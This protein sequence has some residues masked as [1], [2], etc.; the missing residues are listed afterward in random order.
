[1]NHPES[2][3][4]ESM[5]DQQPI[6][7]DRTAIRR[8]DFSLPIK[9]LLRDGLVD[10]TT[11]VFDYGCGHGEDIRFLAERGIP[12]SG[13]DPAFRPGAPQNAADVVNIGY[14]IN[15]I[16][17]SDER[18][19]TLRRAWGLC[20][21]ILAVSAQIEVQGRGSKAVP[22]ADGV[23]T[24][25]GTFQKYFTQD[26]LRLYIETQL[27]TEPVAAAPG[28]FLVFR[29]SVLRESWLA[30]RYRRRSAAPPKRISEQRFEEHRAILEPLMNA[31]AMLGRLPEADEWIGEEPVISIFGS[32]KRAFALI[33][34]VT[35]DEAW[36]LIRARKSEDFLVYLALAK[37]R[38]RPPISKL[39]I[40]LQ[41]DIR[42]FFGTYT[43]AC[44][45]ADELLF[46]A[47][48]TDAIDAACRESAIGKL[49]PNALYVHRSALDYLAPLL[50]V[51]EGC[52][53][54][55]IGEVADANLVKLHRVSGKVSYLAYP[56]FE[57]DPHP[58][59][60]RGVKVALRSRDVSCYDYVDCENP[61]VLHRKESFLL[62]DHPL[63]RKFERLT[64]QEE[65]HGLLDDTSTIGTRSGWNAHLS[66]GG[67]EVRGHRLLKRRRLEPE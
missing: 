53:R 52:A 60:L 9:C 24:R 33:R 25:L 58:A 35:G 36:E 54:K 56:N 26:D 7:R 16:E 1:M 45:L 15:T 31:V 22:Y 8:T 47:G 13:W 65:R 61:P 64:K 67:Y 14:V 34:R 62:S 57:D 50:R 27:E 44:R 42:A 2:L 37:F 46:R 39:P 63:H 23:V 18:A 66:R 38:R 12:V 41:R 3:T 49:L 28:V 11:S 43:N 59:L 29:D 30:R 55:Y 20:E 17:D 40:S 21:K 19:A 5:R 4:H 51:Y 32:T 10:A 6:R 48:D